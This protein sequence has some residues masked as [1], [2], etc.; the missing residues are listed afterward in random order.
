METVVF[1]ILPPPATWSQPK[2]AAYCEN[3][4]YLLR[5]QNI[6]SVSIPE[7][8]Q[9]HRNYARTLPC[10]DKIDALD[11][12]NGL[13]VY[14]P[15]LVPILYKVCVKMDKVDFL[16]WLNKVYAHGVRHVV[17]VGGEDPHMTYRGYSVLEA[18]E[19]I[20]RHFPQM[21]VGAITIFTRPDEVARIL[22]KIKA[23]IDFFVS[24][25]VFEAANLKYVLHS[26]SKLCKKENIILPRIY[27]SLALASKGRDVE[28]MQWLGVEFP[29][30]VL[31][32]LQAVADE[33]V[34]MESLETIDM[35]L[36]EIFH[37][38]QKEQLDL[39]FNIEHIMY[40]N[41]YSC[42]KLMSTI[43][44]RIAEA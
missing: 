2:I 22:D 7:V 9:E 21:K 39:G 16:P 36:D 25:I 28:F 3:I 19:V 41:L 38:S 11:F 14:A 6:R 43:K 26:V 12:F 15:H 17:L 1:E 44:E 31:N 32:C 29:V 35:M 24:Q 4:C 34:E 33:N 20:K 10:V 8:V 42:Q 40:A 27:I 5:Q 37:F 18:V 23:G 13:K 30:A